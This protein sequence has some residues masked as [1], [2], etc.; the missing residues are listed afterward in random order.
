ML[1]STV[2]KS[3]MMYQ[4]TPRRSALIIE[5][6][7]NDLVHPKGAFCNGDFRY[8]IP[9]INSLLA[10]P[11][12]LLRVATTASPPHDHEIMAHNHPSKRAFDHHD[13]HCPV[14]RKDR[15]P[16]KLPLMPK[17]LQ[18]GTWGHQFLDGFEI[19]KVDFIYEK[20]TN[21]K[22][23]NFSCFGDARGNPTRHLPAGS[24]SHDLQTELEKRDITDI[25]VPGLGGDHCVAETARAAVKMGY[26][27]HVVE[28]CL[29]FHDATKND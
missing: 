12:F 28:D 13:H 1:L 9:K 11:G 22:V 23:V 15:K 20:L 24:A 29:A 4:V 8:L 26:T 2:S 16:T 19:D 18:K 7:Q 3:P 25:F 6:M 21:S 17:Y 27:S 5:H 10:T 14:K